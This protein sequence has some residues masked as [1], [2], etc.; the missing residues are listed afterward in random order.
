ML[1]FFYLSNKICSHT[2]FFQIIFKMAFRAFQEP[3]DKPLLSRGLHCMLV[4]SIFLV[5]L[6]CFGFTKFFWTPAAITNSLLP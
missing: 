5:T 4:V 6:R 1:P 3:F 2:L